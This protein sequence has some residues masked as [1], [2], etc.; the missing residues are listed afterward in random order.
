M[1]TV[2]YLH[3]HP[4]DEAS[5]SAGTIARATRR[6]DRVVIVFATGGEHGDAPTALAAGQSVA[7]YRRAEAEASAKVTGA[8]RIAW[9]GYHDSGMNGWDQN[10]DPAAFTN[11]SDEEAGRRLADILDDEHADVLVGYDWHGGY[12]HPDHVKVHA[13][14]H[15][16][17]GLAASTPQLLDST[18]N[19]DRMREFYQQAVAAGMADESWDPDGPADDG[20]PFGEPQAE[21]S[22]R[23]DTRDLIGVTRAALECHAS[24]SDVGWMLQMPPEQFTEMFGFEWFID[25]AGPKGL[26]EVDLPWE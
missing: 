9:L 14:A 15:R 18:M 3:A 8:A 25:P 23:V 10:G 4:D 21:I 13:V 17:A 24:Q 19:R 2:V 7:D 11:A 20:N 6:G 1:T 5:G 26:R 12:G 22:Y 16:A